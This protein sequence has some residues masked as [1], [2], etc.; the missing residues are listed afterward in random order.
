MLKI[1]D[2][3]PFQILQATIASVSNYVEADYD[4]ELW[5]IMQQALTNAKAITE[6]N[7]EAEINAANDALT[8]AI[9]KMLNPSDADVDVY[10]RQI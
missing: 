10:K 4:S 5:A 3:T 8:A 2:A 7:T 6:Q 1:A 9:N